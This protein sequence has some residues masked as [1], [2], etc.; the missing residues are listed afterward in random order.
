M[1]MI[2]SIVLLYECIQM[3]VIILL[4]LV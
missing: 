2:E 3:C 4:T 1:F